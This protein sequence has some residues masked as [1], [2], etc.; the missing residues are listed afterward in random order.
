MLAQHDLLGSDEGGIRTTLGENIGTI[1]AS[2]LKTDHAAIESGRTKGKIVLTGFCW[3]SM[4]YTTQRCACS[5]R[6]GYMGR[7]HDLPFLS[8]RS[9]VNDRMTGITGHLMPRIARTD[10]CRGIIAQFYASDFWN[11]TRAL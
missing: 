2:N 1:N 9:R 5:S 10:I 7:T 6:S 3:R 4:A 8:Q 11:A